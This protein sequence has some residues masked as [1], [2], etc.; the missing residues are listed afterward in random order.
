MKHNHT[1]NALLLNFAIQTDSRNRVRVP[2]VATVWAKFEPG[3]KVS[4]TP[5]SKGLVIR[6]NPNGKHTVEK[7]GAIRFRPPYR[8][9]T[10]MRV[11]SNALK[12]YIKVY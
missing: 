6:P 12:G 2:T 1:I 4:I 5:Y 8:M 9:G 3:T 11:F 10:K 7:D